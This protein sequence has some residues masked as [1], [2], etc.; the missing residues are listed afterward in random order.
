MLI[1]NY[2]RRAAV[3]DRRRFAVCWRD[4]GLELNAEM[5]RLGGALAY[6]PRNDPFPRPKYEPQEAEARVASRGMWRSTFFP[7]WEW[8]HRQDGVEASDIRISQ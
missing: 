4:D 6:R 8:R 1:P 3:D 5:V 7:P 2:A